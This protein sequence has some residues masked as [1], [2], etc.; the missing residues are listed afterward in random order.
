MTTT[1]SQKHRALGTNITLTLFNEKNQNILAQSVALIDYYEDLFT[2]NRSFSE[3]ININQNAGLHPVKVS[4]STYHLVKTAVAISQQNKGFNALI[5]PLVSLWRIGFDNAKVP[6]TAEIATR[7]T[8]I[9]P[10]NVQ[11]DDENLQVFLTKQGMQ[12]DLGA[13]AK[14]YIADRIYNLWESYDV[15]SGIINLGGNLLFYHDSPRRTDGKWVIGVQDPISQKRGEILASVTISAC[16]AVTSGIYERQL[17]KNGQHYHHILDSTTGYP[18]QTD[19]LGVTVFT[20]TSLLAEIMTTQLFFQNGP[21]P[22]YLSDEMYGA[23]FVTKDHQI[24]V[25]GLKD[26]QVTLHNAN[27]QLIMT[28]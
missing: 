5:G 22:E 19:L 24:L 9:D 17:V 1:I 8:E 25:S 13:I 4:H 10:T 26:A 28:D 3:V 18:K 7:L 16:S 23:V 6:T 15:S 20:K 11:F 14:G 2:V 12:L 27:Y 21:A